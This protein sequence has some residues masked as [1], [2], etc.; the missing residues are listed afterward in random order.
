MAYS[1][2]DINTS[3]IGDLTKGTTLEGLEVEIFIS[4]EVTVGQDLGKISIVKDFPQVTK[5]DRLRNIKREVIFKTD[6]H[7]NI[8]IFSEIVQILRGQGLKQSM[9]D[10]LTDKERNL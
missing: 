10:F 5:G 3:I 8:K 1:Q 6:P 7:R 4:E 9:R 2:V